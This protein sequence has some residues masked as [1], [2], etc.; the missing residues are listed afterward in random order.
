MSTVLELNARNLDVTLSA[1]RVPVL[2]D[3]WGDDC[4][5]CEAMKPIVH[6]L[7]DENPRLAVGLFKVEQTDTV[8]ERFGLRGI[9]TLILFKYGKPVWRMTGFRAKSDLVDDLADYLL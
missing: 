5:K 7:A 1:A 8:V 4:A 2:V 6:E 3:F 9:L